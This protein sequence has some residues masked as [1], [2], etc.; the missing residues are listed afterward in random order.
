[1]YIADKLEITG[2]WHHL[3][4]FERI[5]RENWVK[6]RGQASK[7]PRYGHRRGL[8]LTSPPSFSHQ[9]EQVWHA[10]VEGIETNK[11]QDNSNAPLLVQRDWKTGSSSNPSPVSDVSAIHH[12][13]N[14]PDFFISRV[15]LGK[16]G[17]GKGGEK[18]LL[19][20]KIAYIQMTKHGQSWPSS[21]LSHQT[22]IKWSRRRLSWNGRYL[23]QPPST[24]KTPWKASPFPFRRGKGGRGLH[25]TTEMQETRYT[26]QEEGEFILSRLVLNLF[27]SCIKIEREKRKGR[28]KR[29]SR[30]SNSIKGIAS[31]HLTF[32]NNATEIS[33]SYR[34]I[35][36]PN[37]TIQPFLFVTP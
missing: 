27:G 29:H 15:S 17:R 33:Y 6:G 37:L 12:P 10:K 35:D 32:P 14:F 19:N 18:C 21:A 16:M 28:E 25:V 7:H 8:L 1:M 26:T 23:P 34:Y 4:L 24:I 30:V 36:K 20:W 11:I 2:Q 22:P 3:F 31:L 5:S 13:T 9:I